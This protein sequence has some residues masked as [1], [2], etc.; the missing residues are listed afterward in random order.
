MIKALI[1]PA[2][3]SAVQPAWDGWFVQRDEM[4]RAGTGGGILSTGGGRRAKPRPPWFGSEADRASPAGRWK[5]YGGAGPRKGAPRGSA[6]HLHARALS[7]PLYP[8]RDAIAVTAPPPPH[9]AE[10]VAAM[11]A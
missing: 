5:L 1:Q 2:A 10:A 6:L 4:R 9:I 3:Q 8:K 7:I 11:P